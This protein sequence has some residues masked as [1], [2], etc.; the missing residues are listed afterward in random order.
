MAKVWI[1]APMRTLTAGQEHVQAT[2][3]T[4]LQIIEHLDKEYPGIKKS[5]CYEDEI[6]PGIAVI[7]DGEATG[8]GTL[9]RVQKDSEVHFLPAIGGGVA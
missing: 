7:V 6:M 3:Y 8:M 5:L 1:P 4:I 2:G 9:E